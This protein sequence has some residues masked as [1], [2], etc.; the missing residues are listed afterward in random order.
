MPFIRSNICFQSEDCY[1]LPLTIRWKCGM[2]HDRR[3]LQVNDA[4]NYLSKMI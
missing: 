4:M 3:I 1:Y 2:M